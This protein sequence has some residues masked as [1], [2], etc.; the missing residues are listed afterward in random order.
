MPV[1][2]EICVLMGRLV[3]SL[4]ASSYSYRIDFVVDPDREVNQKKDIEKALQQ[5]G[6]KNYNFFYSRGLH[7]VSIKD[8]VFQDW[9]DLNVGA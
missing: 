9:A 3:R 1:T 5:L 7:A 4:K 2:R 6:I 8:P